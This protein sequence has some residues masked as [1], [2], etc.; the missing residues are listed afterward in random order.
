[1]TYP[2]FD[3]LFALESHLTLYNHQEGKKLFVINSDEFGEKEKN[4][5]WTAIQ[6][7]PFLFN[8]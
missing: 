4:L 8:T 1:M 7:F 5:K 3:T 2:S 6:F